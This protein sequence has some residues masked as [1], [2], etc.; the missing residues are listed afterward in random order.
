MRRIRAYNCFSRK[1]ISITYSEC[2]FVALGIHHTMRVRHIV[3]CGLNAALKYFS[4]LSDKRSGFR[5]KLLNTKCVFWFSVQLLSETFLILGI[6]QRDNIKNVH[7]STCKVPVIL[8]RFYET[9]IF[10]KGFR[11]TLKYQILW[12]S[13]EW[14]T[15]CSMRTDGGTDM[16]NEDNS[17]F[18][19][20][21]ERA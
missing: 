7:R 9:W 2:V 8:V 12:K 4:T 3:I 14:E 16:H 1:A 5:I 17:R 19:Q 13:V 21:C 10:S 18:V 11:K 6:N 20:F 15:S